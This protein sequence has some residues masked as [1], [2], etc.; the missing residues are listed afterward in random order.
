MAQFYASIQ[1]N[2]G[3]ATRLGT[4][5]SGMMT[6]AASWQGA[7]KTYLW[8]NE[9]KECDWAEV[10]LMPWHGQGTHRLLY[11]GPVSGLEQS[12]QS[13]QKQPTDPTEED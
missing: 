4:K 9:E 5:S 1:G 2:R 3:E 11:C 10:T 8:Y 13:E 12:E 7:V 6:V